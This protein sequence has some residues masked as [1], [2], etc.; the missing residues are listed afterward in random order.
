MT[1]FERGIIRERVDAGFANARERGVK[2]G[3][4]N[5][6]AVIDAPSDGEVRCDHGAYVFSRTSKPENRCSVLLFLTAIP[7]ARFRRSVRRQGSAPSLPRRL[8]SGQ[9]K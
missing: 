7:S 3:R 4:P 5:T 6:L 1:E 8:Q 2:L 9:E